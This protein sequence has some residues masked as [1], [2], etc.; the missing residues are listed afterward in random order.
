M[1]ATTAEIGEALKVLFNAL[2]FQRG[3]DPQIAVL[4][5]V[6]ALQGL[7]S[8]AI[9][10]GVR[11]FLRGECDG[12]SGKFVPTPPEL[13]RICRTAVVPSRIPVERRVE[14][15]QMTRAER[16]RMEFKMSLLS[17]ATG[18]VDRVDR[19]RD[20]NAHGL[21]SLVALGREWSVPVPTELQEMA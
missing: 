5:Y 10:E 11:K 12:I 6:E 8:E 2:P 20:A 15:P 3:T 17:A 13:A 4:A 1:T 18:Y 9:T 14:A 19:L 16:V 21:Q 7:S